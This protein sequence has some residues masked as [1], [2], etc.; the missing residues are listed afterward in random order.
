MKPSLKFKAKRALTPILAVITA[1]LLVLPLL[2]F[3]SYSNSPS[4]HID[5]SVSNPGG[6]L[7]DILLSI[8]STNPA[9]IV[10]SLMMFVSCLF[11]YPIYAPPLNEILEETIRNKKTAG[12]FVADSRRLIYR[13]LQTAMI[14][15]IAWFC[16]FFGDIIF[17]D[18]LE[19]DARWR[20]L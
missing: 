12:M 10:V 4:K 7:S 19:I 6:I 15:T 20:D 17:F 18:I 3:F 16:P 1:C 13:L 8:P 2:A 5:R 14:S 11:T 9:A